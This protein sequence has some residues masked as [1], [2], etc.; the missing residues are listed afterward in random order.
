MFFYIS[1][2]FVRYYFFL[3]IFVS[4]FGVAAGEVKPP[5]RQVSPSRRFMLTSWLGERGLNQRC[6][7]KNRPYM[8]SGQ[9]AFNVIRICSVYNFYI[10]LAGSS[11]AS[12]QSTL[13]NF[14]EKNY[15]KAPYVNLVF[16]MTTFTPLS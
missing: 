6:R 4:M 14:L 12:G 11:S 10:S 13:R 8:H 3:F 16:G 2:A 1:L 7:K 15:Q 9:L 5:K